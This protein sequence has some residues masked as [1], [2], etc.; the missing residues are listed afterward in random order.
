MDIRAAYI[1]EKKQQL[2][3]FLHFH[4]AR[5]KPE[6]EN[7]TFKLYFYDMPKELE[8]LQLN[9]FLMDTELFREDHGTYSILVHALK[10]YFS[11]PDIREADFIVF[12][13]NVYFHNRSPLLKELMTELRARAG[14]KRVILFSI[15][16]FCHKPVPRS[17]PF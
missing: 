4:R 5:L 14:E 1:T 3:Q 9:Y 2:E 11:T 6:T 10:K 16:D 15:S 8:L 7:R 17:T 12:P 13:F